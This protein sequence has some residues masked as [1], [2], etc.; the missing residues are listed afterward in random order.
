[1]ATSQNSE[2]Y[3]CNIKLAKC[4]LTIL[5]RVGGFEENLMGEGADSPRY[6]V[7]PIQ[8]RG[9]T[10]LAEVIFLNV[11]RTQK[12]PWGKSGLAHAHY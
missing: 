9:V 5:W 2:H 3:Q 10:R 11:N 12:L 4:Y 7:N 6:R 1:M 8:A